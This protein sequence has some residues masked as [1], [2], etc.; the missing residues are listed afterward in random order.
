MTLILEI[1]AGIV[2]GFVILRNLEAI[3]GLGLIAVL[4]AA[5]LAIAGAV[6]YFAFNSPRFVAVIVFIVLVVI[7]SICAEYISRRTG[8]T[9]EEAGKRLLLAVILT[10]ATVMVSATIYEHGIDVYSAIALVG[11]TGIW[12][13]LW[14]NTSHLVRKRKVEATNVQTAT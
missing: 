14:F 4:V 5:L 1:A 3:V 13:V 8:L 11:I 7:G 9:H 2:L 12:G 6:I 10:F